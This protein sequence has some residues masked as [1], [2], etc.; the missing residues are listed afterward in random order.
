MGNQ[1]RLIRRGRLLTLII[2]AAILGIL[3]L[4]IISGVIQ[5]WLWMQQLNYA[6]IFWTL[7]SVKCNPGNILPCPV[8]FDSRDDREESGHDSERASLELAP[9]ASDL[10]SNP[11]DTPLLPVL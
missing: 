5:K 4:A 3:I 7:L 2:G 6:G 9:V 8:G 1:F 11:G 10:S